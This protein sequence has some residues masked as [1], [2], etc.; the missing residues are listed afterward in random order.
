MNMLDK[1]NPFVK[2]I[3]YRVFLEYLEVDSFF[4]HVMSE[5]RHEYGG[6]SPQQKANCE[7][8]VYMIS[9]QNYSNMVYINNERLE[10]GERFE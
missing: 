8:S 7:F 1:L 3:H 4:N 10:I 2:E 5:I 6:G 9:L